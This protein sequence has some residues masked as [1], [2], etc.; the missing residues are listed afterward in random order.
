MIDGDRINEVLQTLSKNK[1][2]TT[3]TAF[4]VFWG[5]FMLMVMLGSGNGL[6]NGVTR[7]FG[8]SAT[9]AVYM[10]TQKTTIPY[11]GLP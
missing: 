1:L 8:G 6:Q 11:K 3:L 10:W 7:S 9:N 4:G 2:R 5:I